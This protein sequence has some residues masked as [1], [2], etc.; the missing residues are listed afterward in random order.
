MREVPTGKYLN[1][2]EHLLILASTINF[3]VSIS[4]FASLDSVPVFVTSSAV[5]LKTYGITAGIKKYKSVLKKKKKHDNI[6]L[7]RKDKL[8][9][10]EVLI[11][12]VLLF[13]FSE[14]FTRLIY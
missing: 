6:V 7:F 10:I 3:C 9:T 4:S 8:N 1:Y 13:Y 12:L 14:V 11:S 2:V 5:G